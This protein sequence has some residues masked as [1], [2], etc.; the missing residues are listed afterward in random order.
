MC[1]CICLSLSLAHTRTLTPFSPSLSLT[2]SHAHTYT[3][4]LSLV[5]CLPH[6]PSTQTTTVRPSHIPSAWAMH[7]CLFVLTTPICP[8]HVCLS[9]PLPPSRASTSCA[10]PNHSHVP[11]PRLPVRTLPSARASTSCAPSKPHLP[12]PCL[13]IRITSPLSEPCLLIRTTSA[14]PAPTFLCLSEPLPPARAVTAWVPKRPGKDTFCLGE[15]LLGRL[16]SSCSFWP[17]L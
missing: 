5:P 4:F 16:Y 15:A 7:S 9:E 10:Y 2:L 8:S 13:L 1:A 11:E 17:Y 3:H 14:C 12:M 6:A